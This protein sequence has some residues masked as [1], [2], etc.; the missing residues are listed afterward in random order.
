MTRSGSWRAWRS[1]ASSPS[2]GRDDREA[3]LL[4]V[5]PDEVDDVALVV[6]DEDRLHRAGSTRSASAGRHRG[7][8]Y[9]AARR[10]DP[11]RCQRN[12]RRSAR[13]LAFGQR[14]AEDRSRRAAGG[15]RRARTSAPARP[16]SGWP[17]WTIVRTIQSSGRPRIGPTAGADL[18]A[19]PADP[20]ADVEHRAR[21][22]GS[23]RR[24]GR[25]RRRR[26]RPDPG[27]TAGR[28][29]SRRAPSRGRGSGGRPASWMARS[30]AGSRDH[31]EP[32]RLAC[33]CC[34]PSSARRRRVRRASPDRAGVGSN[35]RTWRVRRSGRSTVAR[36]GRLMVLGP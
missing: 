32:P 10:A 13:Q 8:G 27:P 20:G 21:R 24:R 5:Q 25:R 4:E 7:G 26:G 18:G 14:S 19:D 23:A 30:V 29:R 9:A 36:V 1:S 33:C 16:R 34:S 17:S 2:C 11:R 35:S 6:D 12:V 15:P 31:D 22:R 28:S 3:L